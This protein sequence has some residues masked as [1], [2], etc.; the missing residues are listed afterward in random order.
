MPHRIQDERIVKLGIVTAVAI[1]VG[2][3]GKSPDHAKLEAQ[4][5]A[6]GF[7]AE[8]DRVGGFEQFQGIEV[9]DGTVVD[10]ELAVRGEELVEDLFGCISEDV[11]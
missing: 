9:L 2:E 3:D 5:D 8:D 10:D 7:R 1:D 11:R 6:V 4:F